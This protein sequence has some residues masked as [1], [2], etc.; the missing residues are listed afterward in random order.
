MSCRR[1]GAGERGVATPSTASADVDDRQLS[2]IARLRALKKEQCAGA[3]PSAPPLP[4]GLVV[5]G[6]ILCAGMLYLTMRFS[7]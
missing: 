6:V 2:E 3:P 4:V 7:G 5:A 1:K